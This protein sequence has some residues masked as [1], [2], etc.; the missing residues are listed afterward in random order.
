[1]FVDRV[2]FNHIMWAKQAA[3]QKEGRPFRIVLVG[4]DENCLSL[5][6]EIINTY[7]YSPTENICVL[8]GLLPGE[9]VGLTRASAF[10]ALKD[11][12]PSKLFKG[13]RITGSTPVLVSHRR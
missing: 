1:M 3:Y 10:K 2:P 8:E 4:S 5:L 13:G 9:R 7:H 11:K 6:N 12:R